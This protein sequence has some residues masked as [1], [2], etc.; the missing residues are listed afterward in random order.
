MY[1]LQHSDHSHLYLEHSQPRALTSLSFLLT[2]APLS[3]SSR[4][5]SRWPLVAAS[6]RGVIPLQPGSLRAAPAPSS[7]ATT[8]RCPWLQASCRGSQPQWSLELTSA[9]Y[10]ARSS[11]QPSHA[12]FWSSILLRTCRRLTLISQDLIRSSE[13]NVTN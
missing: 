4:T 7:V 11:N 2:S 8:S 9:P 3:T 10:V 13:C 5:T 1:V 12:Q 6:M